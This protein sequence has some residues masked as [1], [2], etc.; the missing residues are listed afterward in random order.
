MDIL[1]LTVF[2]SEFDS[3]PLL[4][5]AS[6]IQWQKRLWLSYDTYNHIYVE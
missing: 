2:S 1:R 4:Q 3:C 5:Y 6:I